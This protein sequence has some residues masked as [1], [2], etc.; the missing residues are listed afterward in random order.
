MFGN[1]HNHAWA[2]YCIVGVVL[3]FVSVGAG[4]KAVTWKLFLQAVGF[5]C[6]FAIALAF[7]YA[8]ARRF[9]ITEVIVV[10]EFCGVLLHFLT[11]LLFCL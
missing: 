5:C 9:D 2:F 3:G 7:S 8:E 10:F 1:I 6:F 4:S 11:Y